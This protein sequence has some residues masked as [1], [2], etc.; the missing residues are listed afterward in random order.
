MKPKEKVDLL[1]YQSIRSLGM[2]TVGNFKEA[3]KTVKELIENPMKMIVQIKELISL[4][5]TSLPLQKDSIPL[6][7]SVT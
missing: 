1:A 3:A 4:F 5:N 2:I 6:I 7:F